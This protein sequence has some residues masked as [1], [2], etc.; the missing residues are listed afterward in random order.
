M[1]VRLAAIYAARKVTD[2]EDSEG[3]A[4]IFGNK[5]GDSELR[6]GT[7]LALMK[8]ATSEVIDMVKRVLDDEEVNQGKSKILFYETVLY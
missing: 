1:Y 3:F 2:C 8:C 7:Y 6:I 5:N 4:S